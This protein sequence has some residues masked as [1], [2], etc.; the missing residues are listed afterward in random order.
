MQ[1]NAKKKRKST[2][3]DV[4]LTLPT[5]MNTGHGPTLF[6]IAIAQER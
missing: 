2:T 6:V 4:V 1:L 3:V 5:V